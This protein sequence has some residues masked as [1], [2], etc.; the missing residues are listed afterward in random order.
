MT[1]VRRGTAYGAAAYLLWGLFPLYW[2]LLRPSTALEVLA[3][4]ILWSLAVVVVLLAVLRRLPAVLTVLRDRG[5]AW[6]LSLAAVVIAVNWTTYIYGVSSGQVV[7]TSLGYFVNPIVTVLL[8]VLVLGERL[9]TGQWVAMGLA[10]A[11]VVLLTVENG[12]PPWLALVLA[13]SFGAYGLLKK[14]ARVGAVEGLGV[15]TLVLL[16]PAGAFV[17]W[18][19][20]SGNGTFGS[21]GPAHAGLLALSGVVT[22]VPLLL[23]GAAASRVPLT[24][25]GILQYLAPTLQFLIGV[26][27]YDEPMPAVKLLGFG[28]VWVALVLFTSESLRQRRRQLRLAVAEPA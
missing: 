22:A 9:R 25:L 27:L 6:R 15:E 28:L 12:R 3:H 11:A 23:F 24:T 4:R 26:L 5:R 13:F 7:E 21:E 17:A 18:L 20:A 14:T 10:G 8:G 19:A 2:P 1:A 16:V